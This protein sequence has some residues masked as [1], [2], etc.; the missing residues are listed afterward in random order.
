[1]KNEK[2]NRIIAAVTVNAVLLI[3]IFVAVL[4]YQIVEIS[5]LSA[6]K[7]A[8]TDEYNSVVEELEQSEDW[9]DEFNLNQEGIM[10]ILA[11]QN[12]YTKP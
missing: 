1:M 2:R 8:L 3:V 10:Y 7:K 4:I 9:L 5:I 12:G 6:R 11:L